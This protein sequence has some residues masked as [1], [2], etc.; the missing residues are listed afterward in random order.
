MDIEGKVVKKWFGKTIIRYGSIHINTE[1]TLMSNHRSVAKLS[2]SDAQRVI[3]GQ[4]LGNLSTDPAQNPSSIEHDINLLQSLAK[5]VR[6]QRFQN[7]TLSLESLTLSFKLGED[8]FPIDCGQYERSEANTL[9]EEV[10]RLF[11]QSSSLL[12]IPLVSSCCWST[13]QSLSKLLFIFQN[14]HCYADMIHQLSA[15]W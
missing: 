13:L 9:I 14:K 3:D 5:K 4:S 8:G 7:G 1:V 15:D 11:S 12:R 10:C 6:N 2:Y